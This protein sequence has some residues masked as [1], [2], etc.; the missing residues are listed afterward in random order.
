MPEPLE[1]H[2]CGIYRH[3][4]DGPELVLAG[5]QNG[6]T[7]LTQAKTFIFNFSHEEWRYGP[8]LPLVTK[9]D[10]V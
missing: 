6:E 10:D 9:Q 2:N 7:G 8:D 5:G 4:T 1:N 3:H